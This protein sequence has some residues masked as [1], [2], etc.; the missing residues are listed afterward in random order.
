MVF[1]EYAYECEGCGARTKALRWD[2]DPVPPCSVCGAAMHEAS[3][4]WARNGGVVDDTVDGHWCETLGHDPVWI[5]SRSQLRREADARGLVNVVR[6][7]DAYYAK[8]RKMHDERIRDE[9]T[10]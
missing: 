4:R 8:Q 10:L 2:Y 7:D 6:N 3:I 1:K 9:R 5:E